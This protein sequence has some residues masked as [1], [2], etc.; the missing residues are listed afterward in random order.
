MLN[1]KRK[2][3]IHEITIDKLNVA[4]EDINYRNVNLRSDK[5]LTLSQFFFPSIVENV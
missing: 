3:V 5:G 4:S 2:C 1:N